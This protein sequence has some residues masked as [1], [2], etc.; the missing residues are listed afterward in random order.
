ME[1]QEVK[2][3]ALQLVREWGLINLSRSGLCARAG[4]PD[5][6]FPNIMGCN[7]SE[8]VEEIRAEGA[9]D[10]PAHVNKR[11]ANPALRKLHILAMAV[12]VSKT[13]GYN[14]ITRDEV[15]KAA[16]VSMGLVTRYFGTMVQLRRAIIRYAIQKEIPEI[17]FQGIA[18][19]DDNARKAPQ[20][21]KTRAAEL[22]ANL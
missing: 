12:E 7:F 8:F 10:A 22:L 6:S 14:R 17:V 3:V 4:I 21:L 18:C 19:G 2:N 9:E 5:G 15:A 11:R 13:R 16:G 20:A 1:R